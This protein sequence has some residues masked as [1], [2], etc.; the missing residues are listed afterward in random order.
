MEVCMEVWGGRQDC[1]CVG[2]QHYVRQPP[3]FLFTGE[4]A[5]VHV[6]GVVQCVH[7]HLDRRCELERETNPN[8]N[9]RP[10]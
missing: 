8:L 1:R 3:G 4:H 5:A 6:R 2:A 9:L 7:A 10:P